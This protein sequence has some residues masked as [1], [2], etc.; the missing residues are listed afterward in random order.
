MIEQDI[1]V[2]NIIS[3]VTNENKAV[4]FYK[5]AREFITKGGFNL[6]SW[7]SNSQLLRTIACADNILDKDTKPK[8][9]GMRWDVQKDELCFAQT[10]IHLTAETDI[11]KRVILN[12]S[13]KI[14][15]P[16]GLLSPITIRAK[17]FLQELWREN[18]EWDQILPTKLCE[19]WIDI[20]T[21][22]QKRINTAFPRRYFTG[23]Q[24]ETISLTLQVF[25]DVSLKAY[26]AYLCK[27]NE[28][29][30]IMA[31]T[32]VAPVKSLTLPQLDLIAAV[33]GARLTQHILSMFIN[34]SNVELWSD[35]QIVLNWLMSKKPLKRFIATV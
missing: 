22:I 34:I 26:I 9:L 3:S 29:K 6:R 13:S 4:Q 11:T 17:L 28:S 20:A 5:E 31:K 33:N 16:L 35:S 18:Y 23:T 14:Y 10:E 1:Y 7:T 21:H 25:S 30:L 2:D 19:T 8:V 24:N 27:G 12:Q 32:R 15:D